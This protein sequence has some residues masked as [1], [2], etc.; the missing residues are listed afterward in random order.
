MPADA[1]QLGIARA[2]ETASAAALLDG[3]QDGFYAIDHDWRI[4]AFNKACQTYFRLARE[5]VVGRRLHEVLPKT[6]QAALN[7]IALGLG[8][9]TSEIEFRS[10]VTGAIVHFK[11]FAIDGG[12][13]VTFRDVTEQRQ[14]EQ[15]A[16]AAA[17]ELETIYGSAP[18]GL[19]LYDRDLRYLRVNAALAVMNGVPIESHIGRT[20]YEVSPGIADQAAG[21]LHEVFRTGVSL[22]DLEV[23]G[24]TAARPGVQRTWL[25]NLAPVRGSDGQVQAVLVSILDIT[26]RKQNERR[27]RVLLNELNHRVKNTLASVQSIAAQTARNAETPAEVPGLLL[28]RLAALSKTHDILTASSWESA[29]VQEVL[30]GELAPYAS[31]GRIAIRGEPVRLTPRAALALGLVLHELATNAAKYGA[32]SNSDGLVTVGWTRSDDRLELVW[33]ES[34]GPPVRPPPRKGFGSRLIDRSVSGDLQGEAE[35]AFPVE[36]VRCRVSL[37]IEGA[38]ISPRAKDGA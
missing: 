33:Q 17:A 16:R 25:R 2:G 10:A 11:T 20:L 12:C 32:L 29:G 8:G 35:L 9:R 13:G 27:T 38:V 5:E 1:E 22:S 23:T 21:P 14:L 7:V 28:A 37:P 24:E 26:E 19:A 15:D 3:L 18:V 36:G 34:G 31:G 30:Q 4:T 6:P